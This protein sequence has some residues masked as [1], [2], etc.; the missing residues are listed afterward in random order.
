MILKD[1]IESSLINDKT[2]IKVVMEKTTKVGNWYQ[3]HI[4]DLAGLN[5]ASI[6]FNASKNQITVTGKDGAK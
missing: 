5:V 4:L 6:D 1:I 3:D 2:L